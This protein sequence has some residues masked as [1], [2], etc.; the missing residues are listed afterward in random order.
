VLLYFIVILL[1]F[2]S[3]LHCA[4]VVYF[5]ML[6]VCLVYVCCACLFVVG[7]WLLCML[8][9][10]M[11]FDCLYVVVCCVVCN[12]VVLFVVLLFVMLL[13]CCCW[14]CCF[15][16]FIRHKLVANFGDLDGRSTILAIR[17]HLSRTD[18]GCFLS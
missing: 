1:C 2:L 3:H 5:V 18:F 6:F 8:F 9:V 7:C 10:V 15:W 12:V 17:L 16:R 13:F 4:Y 14:C 11:L